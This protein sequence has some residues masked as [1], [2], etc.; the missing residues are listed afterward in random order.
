MIAISGVPPS[1]LLDKTSQEPGVRVY[2][3]L[4]VVYRASCPRVSPCQINQIL[5]V[6][7]YARHGAQH[8][9]LCQLDPDSVEDQHFI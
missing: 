3:S 9:H 6:T 7:L 2:Q 4:V 1:I 8:I 5:T